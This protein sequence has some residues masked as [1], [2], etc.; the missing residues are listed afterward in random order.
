MFD[1]GGG[2]DGATAGAGLMFGGDRGP[3]SGVNPMGSD[4]PADYFTRIG[5]S[6]SIFKQVERR[7]QEHE[8]GW[9]HADARARAGLAPLIPGVRR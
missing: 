3:A 4:D 1:F 5:L 2:A 6:E 7:Y 8:R 9:M